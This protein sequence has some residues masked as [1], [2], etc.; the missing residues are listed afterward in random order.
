MR[1]IGIATL[2]LLA[3]AAC[4]Q[5]PVAIH[6]DGPQAVLNGGVLGS[7]HY[8]DATTDGAEVL[9]EPAAGEEELTVSSD[10][11]RNPGVLGSGY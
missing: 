2:A 7:G 10:S 11:E 9:S 4:A 5:S 6:D 1:K 3:T 8:E